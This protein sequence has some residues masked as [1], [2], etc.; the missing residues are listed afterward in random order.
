MNRFLAI[1][2]RATGAMAQREHSRASLPEQSAVNRAL[3]GYV[4]SALRG[5][6]QNML[7]HLTL[8]RMAGEQQVQRAMIFVQNQRVITRS[9]LLMALVGNARCRDEQ[10]RQGV[11][12]P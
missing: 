8:V 1:S 9:D 6:S 5:E 11:A 2:L 12:F 7:H 4:D 3:A 10:A